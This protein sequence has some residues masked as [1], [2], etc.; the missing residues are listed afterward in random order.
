MA[1][2]VFPFSFF[3]FVVEFTELFF[4]F[5]AEMESFLLPRRWVNCFYFS[6]TRQKKQ[7]HETSG[8]AREKTAHQLMQQ[9]KIRH[10][11]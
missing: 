9:Q 6:E 11:A 2:R 4:L 10:F 3:S 5:L 1:G 7:E 8:S